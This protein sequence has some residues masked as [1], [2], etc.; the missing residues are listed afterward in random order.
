MELIEKKDVYNILKDMIC[1]VRRDVRK[2]VEGRSLEY[3]GWL[4]QTARMRDPLDA[5]RA[6][7]GSLKC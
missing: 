1:F 2:M 4:L 7:E 6:A 5:H 3:R